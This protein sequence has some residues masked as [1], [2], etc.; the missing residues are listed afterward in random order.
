MD[1]IKHQLYAALLGQFALFLSIYCF[2][3]VVQCSLI[4]MAHKRSKTKKTILGKSKL[5]NSCIQTAVQ[6]TDL[7]F[8]HETCQTNIV[9]HVLICHKLRMH[10]RCILRFFSDPKK[11][12]FGSEAF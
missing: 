4:K 9:G 6:Q 12:Y 3:P 5:K 8:V 10:F 1:Q 2:R 11:G 7:T